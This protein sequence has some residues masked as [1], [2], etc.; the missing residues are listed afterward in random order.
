MW[1]TIDPKR[2]R[3]QISRH[4]V[5]QF[6]DGSVYH[7]WHPLSE[8]GHITKMSD[9][10]LWLAFV[11]A[12]YIKETGNFEILWNRTPFLDDPAPHSLVEHVSRAFE[13]VF[14]RNQPAPRGLPYIGAGDWN[15]GLSAVGLHERGESIWLGH[16]LVGLLAD[17]SEIFDRVQDSGF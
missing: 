2:C 12:N 15:D 5:H 8:Q 17:W 6:A 16:F 13:Q 14:K 9:D 10:L 4:S 1:L 3:E 7:W 11:T